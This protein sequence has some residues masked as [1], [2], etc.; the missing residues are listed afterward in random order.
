[1]PLAARPRLYDLRPG[2]R[3]PPM[4]FGRCALLRMWLGRWFRRLGRR[5]G[6][7]SRAHPELIGL[8]TA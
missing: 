6:R 1:M 8:P 7:V 5:A 4:R 2:S 3:P